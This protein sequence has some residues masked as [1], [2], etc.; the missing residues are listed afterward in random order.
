MR[1]PVEDEQLVG[2]EKIQHRRLQFVARRARHDRLD[3]VNEFVAEEPDG[4]TGE[5]RQARHG[6]HAVFLHFAFDN[7]EAIADVRVVQASRLSQFGV[8]PNFAG[9]LLFG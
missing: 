3:V 2:N 9:G 4:A 8:P 5:P 6:H 7:F 1:D